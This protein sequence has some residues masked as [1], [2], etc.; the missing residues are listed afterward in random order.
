[1]ATTTTSSEL[2]NNEAH[3]GNAEPQRMNREY[4]SLKPIRLAELP[5]VCNDF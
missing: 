5:P 3:Q 2:N 1:M 4:L